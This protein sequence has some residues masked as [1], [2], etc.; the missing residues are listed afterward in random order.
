MMDSSE[1]S[2]TT[3]LRQIT[4][5]ALGTVAVVLVAIVYPLYEANPFGMA[6]WWARGGVAFV[7]GYVVLFVAIRILVMTFDRFDEDGE[8]A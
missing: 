1:P 7:L 3:R 5:V 4:A 6:D 2:G 8:T